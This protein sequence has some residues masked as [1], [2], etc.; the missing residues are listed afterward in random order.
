MKNILFAGF[1]ALAAT[2][3]HPSQDCVE[4][5]K[6]DC[7]CTLQYDPVCGCNNKTYGNACAAACAGIKSYVKGECKQSNAV[8]LE[9]KIWQLTTFDSG[10]QAQQVPDSIAISVKFEGGKIDGNGG[11]NHIGGGYT[12]NGK[13]LNVTGL[14]STKM[15]CEAAAKWETMFLQRLE[16]SRTYKIENQMLEIDCGDMGKL[17]FRLKP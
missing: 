5:P 3:C 6:P 1:L 12:V 17:T 2:S 7:M 8:V 14:F 16:K 4:N 15:F 11:C 10:A 9:G 13:N